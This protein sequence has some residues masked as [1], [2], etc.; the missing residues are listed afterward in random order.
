[1]E[2]RLQALLSS[3]GMAL[4]TSGGS[5]IDRFIENYTKKAAASGLRLAIGDLLAGREVDLGEGFLPGSYTAETMAQPGF[6]GGIYGRRERDKHRLTIDGHFVTPGRLFARQFVE[7]G[8]QAWNM[9]HE[10]ETLKAVTEARPA[11]RSAS[12]PAEAAAADIMLTQALG[13]LFAVAE[14]YPDLKASANFTQLQSELAE[15]EN[16]IAGARQTY[17][18]ETMRYNTYREKFPAI[19]LASLFGFSPR[20]YFEADEASRQAPKVELLSGKDA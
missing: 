1:M 11:F 2:R 9:N 13:R 10:A 20:E 12:S 17:N 3:A 14:A 8:T 19:L 16:I 15:T 5:W 7:P 4:A 6:T 18:A